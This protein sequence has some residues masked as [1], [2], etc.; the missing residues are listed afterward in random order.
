MALKETTIKST[1]KEYKEQS[2]SSSQATKKLELELT[3]QLEREKQLQDSLD[4][5]QEKYTELEEE[6]T[7]LRLQNQP[8]EPQGSIFTRK[9]EYASCVY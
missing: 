9:K 2:L 3:S 4:A 5:L 6:C 7:A 1:L 8:F